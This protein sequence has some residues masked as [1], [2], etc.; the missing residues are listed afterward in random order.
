[1]TGEPGG[2]G[3]QWASGQQTASA[4]VR[5]FSVLVGAG[6]DEDQA[7]GLLAAVEAGAIAGAYSWSTEDGEAPDGRSEAYT[8]GWSDAV[9]AVCAVLAAAAD[10]P[11]R[12]RGR[13]AA[14]RRLAQYRAT[15][16]APAPEDGDVG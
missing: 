2:A 8:Q 16:P 14:A 12:E 7:D 11:Q 5:L 13:A 1:M 3:Y 4:S 9:T 15:R 10:A 6:I